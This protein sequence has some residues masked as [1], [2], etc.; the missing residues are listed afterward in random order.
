MKNIDLEQLA[1]VSGGENKEYFPYPEG[2]QGHV[3]GERGAWLGNK[4]G[5]PLLADMGRT[6]GRTAYWRL[7]DFPGQPRA[8]RAA[9]AQSR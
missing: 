2:S 3:W 8:T 9:P 7:H 4:V 6:A 5:S 1:N